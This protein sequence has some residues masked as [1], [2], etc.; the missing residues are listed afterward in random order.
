MTITRSGGAHVLA[1]EATQL[2]SRYPDLT[3]AELN[4]LIAIYPRLPILD[5]GLMTADPSI[6]TRLDAFCREHGR[7]LKRSSAGLLLFLI[8]P[9]AVLIWALVIM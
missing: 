3:S 2:I 9:M 4:R 5:V 1:A 8:L 6:S 7:K